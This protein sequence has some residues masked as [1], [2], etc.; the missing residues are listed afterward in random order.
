MSPGLL[1]SWLLSELPK[2]TA[3]LVESGQRR[4]SRRKVPDSSVW[5]SP[6]QRTGGARL[7]RV[8]N[9]N[10]R[11]TRGG[12]GWSAVGGG[13][14]DF[15]AR[16]TVTFFAPLLSPPRR[17]FSLCRQS[18]WARVMASPLLFGVQYPSPL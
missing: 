15:V 6:L 18:Q 4:P 7:R 1:A 3:G 9:M 17:P 13:T 11:G 8:G 5:D 16:E 2:Q 10:D 14:I 12:F